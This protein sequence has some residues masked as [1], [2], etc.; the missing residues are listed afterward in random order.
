MF[1]LRGF[2]I[3]PEERGDIFFRN[4]RL[5]ELHDVRTQETVISIV[6]GVR[7]SDPT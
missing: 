6:T 1:L 3:S 5:S 4:V 2:H 7:T